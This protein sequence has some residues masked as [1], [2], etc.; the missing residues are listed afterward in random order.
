[1]SASTIAAL[2][3]LR[4]AL[5]D[6]AVHLSEAERYRAS[7]DNLRLSRMPAAVVTPAD[8]D[9]IG[10]TLHLANRWKIPVT[11]R[12]AGSATTGATS[13][14]PGSWVLDLSGWKKLHIDPVGQM[15]YVQPGVPVAA[16]DEAAAR[17][18]LFFPPDP[19]SAKY[20]TI[21][22][23]IATNAGGL[24]GAKYGVIRDYVLA[25]EGF[26][27]TG[28]F[29]RWGADLRKFVS[30]FNMRDLWI[31]SEG[32]LGVITGAVL[33]LIPRPEK[34]MVIL[35]AYPGNSEAL[36][37]VREIAMQRL[38]PSILEFLDGQTTDCTARFWRKQSSENLAALP[39]VVRDALLSQP[40]PAFLLAEVD[41][42]AENVPHVCRQ[43][44]AIM[45]ASAI[46]CVSSEDRKLMEVLWTLRRG[47]SQAMFICGSDKL[48]EDIVVPMD[49]QHALL[50]YT[51]KLKAETGLSTPTFGHA[52]DGNFHVHIMFDRN[53]AN[54]V[55]R[56]RD[57]ITKLMRQVIDWGGA[58][59]GE[60]GIGLAKSPF[61]RMQHSDSE[62]RAMRAVKAALDP[63]N[64]LNPD[65]I[66]TETEIW[67][68]PREQVRMPWDH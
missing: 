15:A 36:D 39:E 6:D 21:G 1:M 34:T 58:I 63:V 16:I 51:L 50:E 17:H 53:D 46:S 7:M 14:L 40:A 13:P 42:S 12:G 47:C 62:I 9:G 68:S 35:A 67:D 38:Q 57:G 26:L 8:E 49:A 32:M 33:R 25:L 54:S 18:G 24:R 11:T 45:H 44:Q 27:P 29:V 64:I 56:A 19:G 23:A 37:V 28:E 43:L 65:K 59:T 3:D 55:G 52:L 66:F 4:R 60:H 20:A 30:G 2:E 10:E 61:L 41:G 5:G 22:G 48:N 31:G